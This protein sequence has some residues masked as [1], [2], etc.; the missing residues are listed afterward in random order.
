MTQ[1]RIPYSIATRGRA[2]LRL[3][4]V[5]GREVRTLVDSELAAGSHEAIWD[6][7]DGNGRAVPAGAYF[8]MSSPPPASVRADG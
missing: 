3:L 1:T 5:H 4:D 6:G 7:R 8:S 2:T